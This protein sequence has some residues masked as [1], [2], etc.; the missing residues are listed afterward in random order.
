MQ[1]KNPVFENNKQAIEFK[2]K[3]DLEAENY[4]SK[5]GQRL[6]IALNAFNQYSAVPKR[7]RTRNSPFEI[8]RGF[9]D[10]DDI[11]IDLP[12]NYSV[13]SI[14]EPVE[15]QEKFGHYKTEI[16]LNDKKIVYKRSLTINKGFYAKSEYEE[17]RKFI[18]KIAKNDN[19]K[20]VLIQN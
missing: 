2:E 6:M 11:A 14:P 20:L 17:Y 7:Y 12:E 3:I 5:S 4:A 13:E 19:A 1:W 9:Y 15:F 8:A 10:F 16:Q 18:E